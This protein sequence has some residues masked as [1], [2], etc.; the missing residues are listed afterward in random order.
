MAVM[1]Y[2]FAFHFNFSFTLL[3]E[4]GARLGLRLLYFTPYGFHAS[5]G[6]AS[7]AESLFKP[8]HCI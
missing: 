8:L 5:G 4:N 2:A 7:V 1:F 6:W 3:L